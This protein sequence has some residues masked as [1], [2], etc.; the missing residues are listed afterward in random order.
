MSCLFEV[1]GFYGERGP[2]T[3]V[4]VGLEGV[5]RG[6]IFLS[7]Y[8]CFGRDLKDQAGL[9]MNLRLF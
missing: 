2:D 7:D 3:S 5:S 6:N 4:S 1:G 9:R 8:F